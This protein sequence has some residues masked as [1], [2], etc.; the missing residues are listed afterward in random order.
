V[1]FGAAVDGVGLEEGGVL[2][3]GVGEL[4]DASVGV[5]LETP[6]AAEIDDL[7]PALDGFGNPLSGL[8]VGG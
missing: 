4:V 5:M 1:Q 8:L 3:V 7:D 6:C 2:G